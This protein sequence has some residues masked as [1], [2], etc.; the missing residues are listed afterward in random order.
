M[1]IY[2]FNYKFPIKEL[3][4]FYNKKIKP[5]ITEWQGIDLDKDNKDYGVDYA[6]GFFIHMV[7]YEEETLPNFVAREFAKKLNLNCTIYTQFAC[8]EKFC[9]LPWHKDNTIMSSCVNVLLMEKDQANVQFADDKQ[10]NNVRFYDYNCALLNTK[11]KFHRIV[12][13]S[14]DRIIYRMI[15]LS[16]ETSFDSLVSVIKKYN[17]N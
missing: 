8:V 13:K 12:N 1:D 16:K 15:F 11:E 3:L 17:N 2:K 5:N 6:K 4:E 14:V 7:P 9:S 10:G